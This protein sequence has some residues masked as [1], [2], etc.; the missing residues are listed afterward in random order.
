VDGVERLL[1]WL[2]GSSAGA[3]TRARVARAIRE[4]PRNA[5]QLAEALTLDYSTIRH[6]LKVLGSNGLLTTTGQRYGQVY[7]LSPSFEAKWEAFE[8]ITA[9]MKPSQGRGATH[10]TQ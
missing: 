8:R 6:H 2:F 10:G 7:F 9:K 4:D 3:A 1:W 5:Q